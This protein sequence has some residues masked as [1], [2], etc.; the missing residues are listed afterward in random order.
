V[1]SITIALCSL[2]NVNNAEP[3]VSSLA[4]V[5]AAL[6]VSLEASVLAVVGAGYAFY[7]VAG[8]GEDAAPVAVLAVF[9]LLLA[10]GVGA[11]AVGLWRMRRW[12]RSLAL[13]WQV[14]QVAVGAVYWEPHRGLAVTLIASAAVVIVILARA[15]VRAESVPD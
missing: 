8:R 5:I 4:G 12:A 1:C 14:L 11:A 9:A 15:S 7:A 10:G 13:V 3:P 2:E 6:L